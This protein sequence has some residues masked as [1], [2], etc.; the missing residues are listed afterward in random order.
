MAT[1]GL[2]NGFTLNPGHPQK[3]DFS[4][5]MTSQNFPRGCDPNYREGIAESLGVDM[6][7]L[8]LPDTPGKNEIG[9]FVYNFTELSRDFEKIDKNPGEALIQYVNKKSQAASERN[10]EDYIPR[11]RVD[12]GTPRELIQQLSYNSDRPGEIIE[13]L[14]GVDAEE[15]EDSLAKIQLGDELWPH[16]KKA[17]ERW[18]E[19]YDKAGYVKMAGYRENGSRYRS[20]RLYCF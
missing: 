12:A 8:D 3:A 17:L 9:E 10:T 18:L 16:Q 20:N 1:R 2:T 19:E 4:D 6:K 15:I 5:V 11:I 14:D 13:L 7:K